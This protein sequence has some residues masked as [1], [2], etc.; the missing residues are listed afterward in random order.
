MTNEI[1]TTDAQTLAIDSAVVELYELELNDTTTLF[2]YPGYD[3]D[4]SLVKFHPIGEPNKNN[5]NDANT[6]QA[7]PML[8]EGIESTA[9]GANNRPTITI[10]NVLSVFRAALQRNLLHMIV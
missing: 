10:A 8:L 2:F 1:I 4:N 5:T 7:L 6:Y 9:Q 3:E